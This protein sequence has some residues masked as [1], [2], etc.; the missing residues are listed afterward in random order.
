MLHK[1]KIVNKNK[2]NKP[3]NNLKNK[4]NVKENNKKKLKSNKENKE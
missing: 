2:N 4:N 3:E 1:W